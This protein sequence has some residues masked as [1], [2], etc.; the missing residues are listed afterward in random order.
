V[1]ASGGPVSGSN[2][3]RT[4]DVAVVVG[5]VRISQTRAAPAP[6][7]RR[8]D[9]SRVAPRATCSAAGST[10]GAFESMNSSAIADA[11]AESS[12]APALVAGDPDGA[13]FHAFLS[14]YAPVADSSAALY[15]LASAGWLDHLTAGLRTSVLVLNPELGYVAHL[16][17]LA[18]LSRGGRVASRTMLHSMSLDSYAES[19]A[20]Y[21]LDIFIMLYVV[22]LILGAGKR[23][24]R[25]F[26]IRKG[27]TAEQRWAQLVSFSTALDWGV[28]FALVAAG[29]LWSKYVLAVTAARGRMA[30]MAQLEPDDT[31]LAGPPGAPN[32][33]DANATAAPTNSTDTGTGGGPFPPEWA[34]VEQGFANAAAALAA[35]KT[36][37]VWSV[38]FMT[39][40][41]FKYFAFQS[42]IAVLADTI[43]AAWEDLVHF[44]VLV[45]VLFVGFGTWAHFAFGT[46]VALYGDS[47]SFVLGMFR[48]M[49]LDYDVAGMQAADPSTSTLFYV[50]FMVIVANVVL[51]MLFAV[52]FENYTLLRMS[53]LR[54]PSLQD[55]AVAFA[56]ALPHMVPRRASAALERAAGALLCRK[57]PA[58]VMQASAV[59]SWAEVIRV[60]TKGA[61]ARAERVAADDLRLHLGCSI[62]SASYFLFDVAATDPNFVYWGHGFRGS[63]PLPDRMRD[64]LRALYPNVFAADEVRATGTVTL[65]LPD[66][67]GLSTSKSGADAA[68]D[69]FADEDESRP[70]VFRRARRAALKLM[71]STRA[72]SKPGG[73]GRM[74]SSKLVVNPL[75]AARGEAESAPLEGPVWA[76]PADEEPKPTPASPEGAAAGSAGFP[77]S[78]AGEKVIAVG[79]GQEQADAAPAADA[80]PTRELWRRYADNETG[81]V[82]FARAD[83]TEGA[84]WTLPEGADLVVDEAHLAATDANDDDDD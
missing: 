79:A 35:F 61:L 7:A 62:E 10:A 23:M 31:T 69:S 68:E 49:M 76:P 72:R 78:P 50:T 20:L 74:A 60:L 52:V 38:I 26:C 29:A 83:G 6:C 27:S 33:T 54:W 73:T 37:T 8:G 67:F 24:A 65:L 41:L 18:T 44:F 9:F 13:A 71:G 12:F 1:D 32:A 63:D 36:A 55:E 30:A 48:F 59:V 17:M 4:L 43:A 15:A 5:G 47:E 45:A 66:L 34:L 22:Y 84:E 77:P 82:W 56:Q 14:A 16:H 46:Q 64:S 25:I 53:A 70:S 80:G 51:W 11:G 42:R 58:K 21:A 57:R 2:F 3:A 40:R 28:I 39:L 81:E 75:K 19:P